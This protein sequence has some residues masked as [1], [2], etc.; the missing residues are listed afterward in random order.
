[1]QV[2]TTLTQRCTAYVALRPERTRISVSSGPCSIAASIAR[3]VVV[4]SWRADFELRG[5]VARINVGACLPTSAPVKAWRFLAMYPAQSAKVCSAA[6]SAGAEVV[7]ERRDRT[8]CGRSAT[9]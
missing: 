3:G 2:S 7:G 1:M 6:P 9:G 4:M 5:H 8:G